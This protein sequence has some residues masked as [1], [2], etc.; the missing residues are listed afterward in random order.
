[1][2]RLDELTAANPVFPSHLDI[3]TTAE[4]NLKCPMCPRTTMMTRPTG[5]MSMELFRR[6][7]DEA[8]KHELE[9]VWLHLFGEPLLNPKF[10]DY[11]RYAKRYPSI[12]SIGFSTISTASTS[13]VMQRAS[14]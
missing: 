2:A 4:C 5:H 1:M 14:K 8:G 3:E 10:V 12:R 13:S 6:V 11:I 7:I 9:L